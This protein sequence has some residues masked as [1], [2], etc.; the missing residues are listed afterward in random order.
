MSQPAITRISADDPMVTMPEEPAW[1]ARRVGRGS[2]GVTIAELE[3]IDSSDQA[4]GPCV[5]CGSM[6]PAGAGVTARFH[7]RVL[8]FRCAGCLA[9]FAVDP[10]HLPPDVPASCCDLERPEET[11]GSM[12]LGEP[13][14]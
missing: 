13:L 10:D 4:A 3:L 12:P 11:D 2:V 7:G 1:G 14:I 6:V 5:V 9:R 8:R